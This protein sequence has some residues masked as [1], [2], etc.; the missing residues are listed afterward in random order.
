MKLISKHL[1]KSNIKDVEN[2]N[3][4]C[5]FTGKQITEGVHKSNAI[6][7]TF[8]DHSLLRYDSDYIG[9]DAYATMDNVIQ[10]QKGMVSLRNFS[11]ICNDERLI[12]LKNSEIVN[13]IKNPVDPPFVFCISFSN[14]KHLAIKSKINHSKNRYVVTT[15]AG[16]CIIDEKEVDY[17]LPVIQNWYTVVAEKKDTQSQPTFFTKEEILNGSNNYKRIED[18]PGHYF[19]ENQLIEKYRGT[20]LLKVLVHCLTKKI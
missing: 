16:D 6:K 17:I 10:G 20:M 19:V 13:Y 15:D 9:I 12:L 3:T 11:F 8:T 5:A 2:V 1:D 18:Y 14:K 7:K 4:V